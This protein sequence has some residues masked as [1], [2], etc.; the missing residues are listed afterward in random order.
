MCGGWYNGSLGFRARK[1]AAKK[2]KSFSALFSI[3]QSALFGFY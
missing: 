1:P 2:K 3:A